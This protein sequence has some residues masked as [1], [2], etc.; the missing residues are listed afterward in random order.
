MVYIHDY[1]SA[2]CSTENL[3]KTVKR[4]PETLRKSFY[5][6]TKDVSFVSGD[7]TLIEFEWWLDNRLKE[8]FNLIAN[9]TAKQEEKPKVPPYKAN[10]NAETIIDGRFTDKQFVGYVINHKGL[11]SAKFY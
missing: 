11:W 9:I 1:Q 5:K 2:I 6:A 4:L 10:T 3:T 7:V 8:Y